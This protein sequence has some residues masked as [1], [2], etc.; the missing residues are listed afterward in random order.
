MD[1][2]HMKYLT[3]KS[4]NALLENHS[5][6]L[7]FQTKETLLQLVNFEIKV[8]NT[9]NVFESRND[10]SIEMQAHSKAPEIQVLSFLISS[11]III[12]FFFHITF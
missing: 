2:S 1:G 7:D 4:A 3:P 8:D 12:V 9:I 5:E 6:L 11:A 10:Y